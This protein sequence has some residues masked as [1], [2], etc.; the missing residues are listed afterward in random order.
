MGDGHLSIGGNDGGSAEQMRLFNEAPGVHPHECCGGK[1]ELF[2]IERVFLM[3]R[4]VGEQ[5]ALLIE[6]LIFKM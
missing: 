5:I 4:L 3:S 6:E 2:Q 1:A